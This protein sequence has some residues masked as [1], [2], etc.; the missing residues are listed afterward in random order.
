MDQLTAE[1]FYD[2]ACLPENDDKM[3]EL[4]RGRPQA[5]PL[6][7]QRHGVICSLAGTVLGEFVRKR[8]KGYA[9]VGAGIV[10]RRNPDT[11]RCPDVSVFE[12]YK[13]HEEL[14]DRLSDSIPSLAVE[15]ISAFDQ[16]PDVAEKVVDLLNGGVVMVWVIDPQE[17]TTTVHRPG[18]APKRLTIHD[19]LCDDAAL[20]GLRCPVEEFFLL[21]ADR[22][23]RRSAQ[24][25]SGP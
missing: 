13:S 12:E 14:S 11:V 23:R 7:D 19:E 1:Q 8:R 25:P 16:P 3:V 15:V 17:R 6:P 21:P 5:T 10:L 22:A 9:C 4:V 18:L 2:W 20:P 24:R